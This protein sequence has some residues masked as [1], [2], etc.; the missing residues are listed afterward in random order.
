MGPGMGTEPE[1]QALAAELAQSSPVPLVVDALRPEILKGV[2]GPLVLTPHIG[3]FARIAQG[4]DLHAFCGRAGA[5]VI[6]K[7]PITCI[8]SAESPA[9]YS[10]F[11]GTVLARGGSGDILAGLTGGLLVQSPSELM[12]AACR[13]AVWHGCAADLLTRARGQTAVSVTQLLEFLP[14]V[15]RQLT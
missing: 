10:F 9:C 4:S 11:G 13:A 8:A 5:T 2:K 6:L 14:A 3:E 1:T 12:V 15:L 7:G